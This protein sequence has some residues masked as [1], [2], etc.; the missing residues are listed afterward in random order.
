LG[1]SFEEKGWKTV[2]QGG[3]P[4]FP[5]KSDLFFPHSVWGCNLRKKGGDG[6]IGLKVEG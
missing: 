3:G 4:P 2:H 6:R 1:L 5:E